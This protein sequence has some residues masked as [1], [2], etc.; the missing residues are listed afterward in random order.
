MGMPEKTASELLTEL[1]QRAKGAEEAAAAARAR[2]RAA[3]EARR[4][5]IETSIDESEAE[6]A[7][8][9]EEAKSKWGQ[10]Q[11]TLHKSF[12]EKRA[13]MK[14][15]LE[16]QRASRDAKRAIRRADKAESDAVMAVGLALDAIENAEYEV[17]D[18]V[19]A[20]AEADEL[21]PA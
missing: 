6:L 7:D 20:R 9:A 15:D 3:L 1:A 21:A 16:A 12:G 10:M 18:A 5:A 13:E 11:S 14:A 8:S 4:D 17:I 2:D 19:L